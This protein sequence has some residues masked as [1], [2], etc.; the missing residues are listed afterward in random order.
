MG[1]EE[2]FFSLFSVSLGF[3]PEPNRK[4]FHFPLYFSL[5]LISLILT[6]RWL[7]ITVSIFSFF[8]CIN[9]FLSL[10]L[11]LHSRLPWKFNLT[12]MVIINALDIVA[13]I[14]MSTKNLMKVPQLIS[15]HGGYY[16]HCVWI[17]MVWQTQ[18]IWQ[19][20]LHLIKTTRCNFYH[21]VESN[22]TIY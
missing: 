3:S 7:V 16:I 22:F 18:R 20:F 9:L 1:L 21:F 12:L 14:L 4:K 19:F 5:A 6:V 15:T 13:T 17:I 2:L 8:H 10:S 11:S